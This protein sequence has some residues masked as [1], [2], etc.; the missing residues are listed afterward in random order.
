[1]KQCMR[2]QESKPSRKMCCDGCAVGAWF[3]VGGSNRP[4]CGFAVAMSKNVD[5]GRRNVTIGFIQMQGFSQA[6]VREIQRL[7][8]KG[9]CLEREYLHLVQKSKQ[10]K[11]AY[12]EKISPLPSPLHFCL[13]CSLQ[14]LTLVFI[15]A[16]FIYADK[17]NCDCILSLHHCLH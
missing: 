7:V 11:K 14:V 1:M 17:S 13:L 6:G 16:G 2:K 15:F 10:H 4:A 9:I 3:E 5:T 12:I 8:C